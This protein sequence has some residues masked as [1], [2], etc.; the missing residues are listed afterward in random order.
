MLFGRPNLHKHRRGGPVPAFAGIQTRPCTGW[1]AR[2]HPT[3]TF[4]DRF[5]PPT[6]TFPHIHP[7]SEDIRPRGARRLVRRPHTTPTKHHK[8]PHPGDFPRGRP[9]HPRPAQQQMTTNRYRKN[10]GSG[11]SALFCCPGRSAG[12]QGMAAQTMAPVTPLDPGSACGRP[13]MRSWGAGAMTVSP[14]HSRGGP[15]SQS[16]AGGNPHVGAGWIPAFAGMTGWGCA[17]RAG[18]RPPICC[19]GRSAGT[20]GAVHRW[21]VAA[22]FWI[23][24]RPSAP[25]GCKDVGVVTFFHRHSRAGGNPDIRA[26]WIPAFAG[27]TR[28]EFPCGNARERVPC[29]QLLREN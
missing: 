6:S 27:M 23:P 13:G 19:P 2:N 11:G 28:G 18:D 15:G 16:G 1:R 8:T 26:G 29:S 5:G 20:Q 4:L 25:R 7:L 14:R 3:F 21:W 22:K 24:T 17:P 10:A 12:T 9:R